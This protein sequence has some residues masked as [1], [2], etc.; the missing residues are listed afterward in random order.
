MDVAPFRTVYRFGRFIPDLDR[1]A[2]FLG[3]TQIDLRPKSF[4]VLRFFVENPGRL[5]DRDT[6]MA[7]IWPGT[8]IAEEGVDQCVRDIRRALGGEAQFFLRTV[9]KRG[10]I[11]TAAVSISGGGSQ[12]SADGSHTWSARPVVVVM[13]FGSLTPSEMYLASGLTDEL[14]TALARLRSLSVICPQESHQPRNSRA[15]E[16]ARPTGFGAEYTLEGRVRSAGRRVRINAR[17]VSPA[18][19]SILWANRYEG[20]VAEP[21]AFKILP[22]NR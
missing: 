4:G 9:P 1:G 15:I 10:Y 13:P 22:R 2:L 20:D 16:G 18:T 19:K 8:T 21:S 5:L 3:G 14:V 11:F 17:L 7:A 6:I 12:L